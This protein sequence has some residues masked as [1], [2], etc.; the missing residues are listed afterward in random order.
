MDFCEA[1]SLAESRWRSIPAP[2]RQRV[3]P[4]VGVVRGRLVVAGGAL[5][6]GG[7]EEVEA[8]SPRT[9]RWEP[10]APMSVPRSA[11]GPRPVGPELEGGGG[12]LGDFS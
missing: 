7:A 8:Y 1:F 10:C 3:F 9:G 11:C 12:G 2:R 5:H 6:R 4:A